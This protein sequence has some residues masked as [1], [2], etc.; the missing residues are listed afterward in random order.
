MREIDLAKALE[1][2]L[3]HRGEVFDH[4]HLLEFVEVVWADAKKQP[5]IKK[6][7][8]EFVHEAALLAI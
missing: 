1:V 4:G 7:A 6:W 3:H 2:E 8:D 5:D